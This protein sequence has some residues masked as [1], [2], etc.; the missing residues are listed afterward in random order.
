MGC[1]GRFLAA[2]CRCAARDA[3]DRWRRKHRH[4]QCNRSPSLAQLLHCDM[5]QLVLDG[6]APP[7]TLYAIVVR[8]A[9]P[10]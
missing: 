10:P 6:T 8:G 9:T 7:L 1:S 3:T 2:L 4:L 5:A